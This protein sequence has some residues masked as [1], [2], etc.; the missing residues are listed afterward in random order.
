MEHM[1]AHP[2][3][4]AKPLL[5]VLLALPAAFLTAGAFTGDL[6]ANPVERI[7]HETGEWALRVLI[8]A[9]AIT[10]LRRWTKWHWLARL[11]RMIGLYAFFYV[12]LHLTTYLWLD[13]FFDFGAIVEDIVKRPYITI[14][15]A[16]F[17]GLLPLA[18]TSTDKMVR[19]LGGRRWRRLHQLAYPATILACAH[20]LWLV[21]ADLIE[22]A[23]YAGVTIILLVAR[24]KLPAR[25]SS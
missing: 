2:E 14:G 11:R 20:F 6:G 18:I 25:V 7:T 4:F 16:A 24:M 1:R 5:F 12:A 9:L 10:P 8:A 3:R 23:I 21:K 15:F 22:P 19:R 17:L 13:Q